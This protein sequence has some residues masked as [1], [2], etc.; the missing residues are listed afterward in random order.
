[1]VRLKDVAERAGVSAMTVSKVMRTPAISPR[2]PVSGCVPWRSRWVTCRI[3]WPGG[4]ARAPHV[5]WFGGA[6]AGNPFVGRLLMAVEE[7]AQLAGYELML[8]QS[9][10]LPE[11]EDAALHRMLSRRSKGS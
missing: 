2:P 4:C 10:N 6:A 5:W 9:L 8:A 7:H 3:R 11:R 1:M